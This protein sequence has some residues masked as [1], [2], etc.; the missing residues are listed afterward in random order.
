M[1]AAPAPPTDAIQAAL[2]RAADVGRAAGTIEQLQALADEL[3]D[4]V[5]VL[6]PAA[7]AHADGLWKG[8]RDWYLLV[9]RIG[10]ARRAAESDAAPAGLLEA[11]VR[12]RLLATDCRWLLSEY[13]SASAPERAEP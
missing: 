6:I 7:Q 2:V 13:G 10:T 5:R 9:S 12:V 4:Y 3:R 8:G 11:H 1:S